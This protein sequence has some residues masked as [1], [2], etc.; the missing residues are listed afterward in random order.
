MCVLVRVLVPVQLCAAV[1]C[2]PEN[3]KERARGVRTSRFFLKNKVKSQVTRIDKR[4]I[5]LGSR[6]TAILEKRE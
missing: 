2:V 3:D 6:G 5:Y 4:A 1:C